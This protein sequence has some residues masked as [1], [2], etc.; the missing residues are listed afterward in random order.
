M[1]KGELHF[2]KL[3]LTAKDYRA[4]AVKSIEN[5]LERVNKAHDIAR[6]RRT[7]ENIFDKMNEENDLYDL[8]SLLYSFRARLNDK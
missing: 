1:D 7:S 4:F 6:K 2:K 5:V 3:P 8:Q